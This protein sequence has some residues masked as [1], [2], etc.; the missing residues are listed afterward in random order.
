MQS[1]GM[2]RHTVGEGISCNNLN[3]LQVGSTSIIK[4]KLKFNKINSPRGY[5]SP[6]RRVSRMYYLKTKN[7][8]NIGS[9]SSGRGILT[10]IGQPK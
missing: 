6:N 3:L 10:G 7:T 2:P 4:E 9:K 8:Y 5:S 1:P